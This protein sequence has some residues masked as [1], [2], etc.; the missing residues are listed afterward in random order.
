M[1]DRDVSIPFFLLFK[2]IVS[3]ERW[4][5]S[6]TTS[7][8]MNWLQQKERDAAINCLWEKNQ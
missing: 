6:Q 8:E 1:G 3:I 2:L 4:L 5:K 7:N